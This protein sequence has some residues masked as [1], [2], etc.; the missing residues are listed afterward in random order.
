MTSDKVDT[1]RVLLVEDNPDIGQLRADLFEQLGCHV[2]TVRS[3]DEAVA[4]LPDISAVDIVITDINL[5][6]DP[7]DQSG[8]AF[9]RLAREARPDLPIIGYTAAFSESELP[10]AEHPEIAR[11]FVKGSLGLRDLEDAMEEVVQLARRART[12]RHG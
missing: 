7:R 3:L 4:A 6:S 8:L 1:I 9:A 10:M 5:G 11:W 2:R 12:A